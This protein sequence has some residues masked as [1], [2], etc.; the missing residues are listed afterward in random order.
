MLVNASRPWIADLLE[1][2]VI[3]QAFLFVFL[4]GENEYRSQFMLALEAES[5]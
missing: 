5:G 4:E 1:P 3:S 2:G